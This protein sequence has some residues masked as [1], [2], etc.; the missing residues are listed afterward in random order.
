[1]DDGNAGTT[2]DPSWT[3]LITAPYPE[4]TSGHNCLDASQV[5]VLRLFFGD[6][7]GRFQITSASTFL[8]PAE[9]KVRSF[10]TFSQPLAELI[11]ARIWAGLH[12]RS[13]DV[14]GQVL[15]NNVAAYGIAHYLR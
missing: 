8:A 12:Y 6:T 10:D 11:E 2:A 7:P 15:G 13:S 4:W 1:L 14:A 5:S 9:S 3:A